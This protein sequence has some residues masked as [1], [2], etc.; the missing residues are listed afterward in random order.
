MKD[1]I[2]TVGLP[3]IMLAGMILSSWNRWSSNDWFLFLAMG[4]T[5]T[6]F[7]LIILWRHR[8]DP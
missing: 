5:V 7:L 6:I 1:W 2:V 3:S 4:A 8:W